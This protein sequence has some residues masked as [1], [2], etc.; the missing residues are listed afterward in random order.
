VTE[1]RE[2]F[3]RAESWAVDAQVSA[4]RSRRAAWLI[5][6]IAVA[7]ALFEAI[8]LAMLSPLK[9]VQPV[10]LLVDRHTGFVQAIDPLSPRRIFADEALT[11]SLLAQYVGAREG[12]DRATVTSNYRR[13]ALWSA[14]R[15]RQVYVSSMTPTNP[16]SPFQRYPAGAVVGTRVKSVSRLGS[17]VA[18]VR[19]DTQVEARDGR[20]SGAQPWIAVVRF[21]FVD[22]PMRYE[23]RLI[24]P[25]GFQ[26]VSYRR[27]AEAPLPAVQPASV[28]APLQP[29]QAAPVI[30]REA[31]QANSVQPRSGSTMER[32]PLGPSPARRPVERPVRSDGSTSRIVP[33]NSLP[34]G[35]PL[36]PPTVALAQPGVGNQP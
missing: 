9:T 11:N 8:A 29:A 21:R 5:A 12:F 14:D 28:P 25:L 10:T 4:G 35:S 26:V 34:M 36:A 20:A 24:N 17:G 22:A 19:F 1:R 27:D 7:V 6:G 32:Q 2:Y 30:T 3:E 13:V 23:D 31:P 15:A 18:L 33:F 16:D